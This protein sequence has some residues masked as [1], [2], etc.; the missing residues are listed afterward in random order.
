MKS[1]SVWNG[2]FIEVE[3]I[4]ACSTP[5]CAC[6]MVVQRLP[7][8]FDS[9]SQNQEA[10]RI[11]GREHEIGYQEKVDDQRNFNTHVDELNDLNK[12]LGRRFKIVSFRWLNE[13]EI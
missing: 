1:S 6:E 10:W 9:E 13:K 3:S 5:F 4:A 11:S 2:L 8:Y 12:E 7:E